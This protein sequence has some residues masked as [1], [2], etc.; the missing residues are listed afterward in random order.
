[1]IGSAPTVRFLTGPVPPEFTSPPDVSPSALQT[2][3]EDPNFFGRT[4]SITK[5]PVM[6]GKVQH[7]PRMNQE[8]P[9]P[10]LP[11]RC[12]RYPYLGRRNTVPEEV[13]DW[14]SSSRVHEWT[15]VRR[16][17]TRATH[18]KRLPLFWR[19]TFVLPGRN[20][21]RWTATRRVTMKGKMTP[22]RAFSVDRGGQPSNQS[23]PRSWFHPPS[24]V[25]RPQVSVGISRSPEP[26]QGRG[27]P[28]IL[29]NTTPT[30]K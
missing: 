17:G 1:M 10:T 13:E 3:L 29:S 2:C 24:P 16:R 25:S 5:N 22:G 12:V 26:P 18:G 21:T 8:G 15:A 28:T 6:A 20:L 7:T 4:T 9:P 27:C 23:P 19:T 11:L 30:L 14:M